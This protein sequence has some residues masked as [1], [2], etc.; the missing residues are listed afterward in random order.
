MNKN[1]LNTIVTISLLIIIGFH[2]FHSEFDLFS[3]ETDTEHHD[4]HDYCRLID[5]AITS[6]DESSFSDFTDISINTMFVICSCENCAA[7]TSHNYLPHNFIDKDTP[8][9]IVNRVL[10]I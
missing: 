3:S 2:F 8:P 10:L 4:S 7:L 6:K 1:I 9:Y 5:S